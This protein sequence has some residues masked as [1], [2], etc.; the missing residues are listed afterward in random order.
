MAL[1][2]A[3]NRRSLRAL[4]SSSTRSRG[5]VTSLA[6]RRVAGEKTNSCQPLC[7]LLLTVLAASAQVLPFFLRPFSLM[8]VLELTGRLPCPGSGPLPAAPCTA[9]PAVPGKVGERGSRTGEATQRGSSRRGAQWRG[10][11]ALRGGRSCCRCHCYR[12]CHIGFL[13]Y[14]QPLWS[15]DPSRAVVTTVRSR[16]RTSARPQPPRRSRQAA[17]VSHAPALPV[18]G[19]RALAHDGGPPLVCGSDVWLSYPPRRYSGENGICTF[20]ERQIAGLP[21]ACVEERLWKLEEPYDQ[22][23]ANYRFNQHVLFCCG[24]GSGKADLKLRTSV[25]RYW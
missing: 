19:P 1:Q 21:A 9:F 3:R 2:R 18:T 22:D 12:R 20:R 8:S 5:Q 23:L 17:A 10:E 14:R 16:A 25:S 24:T 7:S 13:L 15:C 6:L 4:S 11:G